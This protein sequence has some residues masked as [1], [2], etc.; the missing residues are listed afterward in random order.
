MAESALLQLAHR[1]GIHIERSQVKAESPEGER[2]LVA[3]LQAAGVGVASENE[4]RSLLAGDAAS[5]RQPRLAPLVVTEQELP[6]RLRLAIP[7]TGMRDYRWVVQEES[8]QQWHGEFTGEEQAAPLRPDAPDSSLWEYVIETGTRLPC[9]YHRL[10]IFQRGLEEATPLASAPL[11]V[12]PASCYIPSGISGRNRVWGLSFALQAVRS[13]SNWGVGDFG[14]LQKVL[15]WGAQQGAGVVRTPPLTCLDAGRSQYNPYSPSSRSHLDPLYVNLEEAIREE[16][17]ETVTNLL[18]DA[19]FQARLAALRSQDNIDYE[20]V[21]RVKE[22]AFRLLWQH[23]SACHLNP[24]TGRGQ[25]FRQFQEKGGELLRSFSLYM[26]IQEH[27]GDAGSVPAGWK[28]W[29]EPL[30]HPESDAV[31]E[32]ARGHEYEL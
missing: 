7:E 8:G 23:F 24:E 11:I 12:A 19:R 4:A 2:G 15:S 26:A 13:G 10:K 9:G 31:M 16:G 3:L 28:S 29:P 27:C 17:G 6:L 1:Y 5:A 22:E 30:R 21:F 25:A 20:A 14:D 18:Q 32:F